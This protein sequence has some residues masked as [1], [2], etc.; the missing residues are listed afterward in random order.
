MAEPCPCKA[1][2]HCP[3]CPWAARWRALTACM[4]CNYGKHQCPGCGVD[5]PHGTIACAKCRERKS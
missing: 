3:E 4:A 1:G 5:I 2:D